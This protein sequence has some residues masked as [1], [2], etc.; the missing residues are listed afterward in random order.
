M[1]VYSKRN[2]TIGYVQGFNFIAGRLLKYIKDEEK[3]FW[4][5][6]QIIEDILPINY[7]S[8]MAGVMIDVDLLVCLMNQK[9]IPDFASQMKEGFFI[10]LKNIIFQWFLSLFILN[11]SD[12]VSYFIH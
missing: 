8:E 12:E 5:F 6:S 3:A 2:L 11:L 4:T 9:Y 7:Y 1:L 10:Y